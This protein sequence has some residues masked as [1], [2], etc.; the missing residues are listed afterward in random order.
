MR[1][2][3]RFF[4]YNREFENDEPGGKELTNEDLLHWRDEEEG[5]RRFKRGKNGPIPPSFK[6]QLHLFFMQ[7]SSCLPMT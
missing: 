7:G 4:Q 3:F 5:E 1:F 2:N 6:F